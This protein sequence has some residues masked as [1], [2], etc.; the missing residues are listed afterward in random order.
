MD[1]PKYEKDALVKAM[2][3]CDTNIKAFEEGIQK[4]MNYKREL[5]TYVAEHEEYEKG[6][7]IS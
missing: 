5:Q 3:K 1:K 6:T 4:E 2:N 7:C